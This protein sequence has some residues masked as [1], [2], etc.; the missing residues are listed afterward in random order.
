MCRIGLSVGA[1]NDIVTILD[2]ASSVALS[3][4][5]SG[6]LSQLIRNSRDV[7]PSTG[8]DQYPALTVLNVPLGV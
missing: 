1:E 2:T 3:P 4:P 5:F 8:C 6:E 7:A